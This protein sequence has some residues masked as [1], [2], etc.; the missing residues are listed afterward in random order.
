MIGSTSSI[1]YFVCLS[2]GRLTKVGRLI[3]PIVYPSGAAVASSVYP[4]SPS[5][6]GLLTITNVWGKFFWASA[7]NIRAPTSVPPPAL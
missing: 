2:W 4:I 5:A 6:P 1:L 7:I 3:N